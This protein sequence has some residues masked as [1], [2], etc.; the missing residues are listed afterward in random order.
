MALAHR[1]KTSKQLASKRKQK[2]LPFGDVVGSN[3]FLVDVHLLRSG[4]TCGH[5]SA[6]RSGR[7][8][9]SGCA[10]LAATVCTRRRGD[11]VQ[12]LVRV[13]DEWV[14]CG[15]A[16]QGDRVH[17]AARARTDAAAC[18]AV[19][20]LR[21]ATSVDEDHRE[22]HARFK[23][24]PH[25]G[26][27]V[28][29]LP[30]LRVRRRPCPWEA[31]AF[32]ICEQLIE[33]DRAVTIQRRL[34]GA[35]GHRCEETGLRA[36][37]AAATIAG[38]APAQLCAFDL[39]GHRALTLLKAAIEVATRPGRP[40]RGRSRAGLEAPAARSRAS[41]RGPS[42]CWRCRGSTATTGSPPATS[43]TSSSSAASRRAGRR[44]ARTSTRCASS[45]SPTASGAGLAG[46]YLLAAAARGLV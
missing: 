44:P 31:L 36:A 14:F 12:R 3:S 45:S 39:P 40:R 6:R 1:R 28:R 26:R 32:A 46:E 19:R 33:F 17:F 18:E 9:R 21:A 37:P 41:A 22:F 30:E 35:Y 27:A 15:V 20:R 10:C 5:A 23:R 25:I 13:G 11:A 2:R 24:D 4:L 29:M 38:L 16:Q 8:G 43:A 34:I 42:R 7:R